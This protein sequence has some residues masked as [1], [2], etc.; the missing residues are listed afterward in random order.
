MIRTRL[1]QALLV[2]ALGTVAL[3]GCRKEEPAAVPPATT[4]ADTTPAPA[5]APAPP[6]AA[7]AS[8]GS[9]TL[10]NA[11]D[12]NN[13]VGTPMST[14]ST[15]DTIHASVATDGAGPGR[16]TAKWTHL[17][18]SQTVAEET[19]DI[20]AGPQMTDFHISKPDGWPTG[21]YRLEV[22]LDGAVVN[23]SE[24]DVQ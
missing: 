19:K 18:S 9:V 21:K 10:G 14:F 11:I 7:P 1:S 5:P 24:F 22:S 8:V 3:A 23:T 6:A 16:L 2:A 12:A 15:G 13:R 17:D 4:P 20:A